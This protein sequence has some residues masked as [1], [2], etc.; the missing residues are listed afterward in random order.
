M[1]F[2][3]LMIA[4]ITKFLSTSVCSSSVHSVDDEQ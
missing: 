3:D 4:D 1:T 2:M